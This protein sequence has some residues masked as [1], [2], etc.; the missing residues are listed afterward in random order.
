ML[1]I[2]DEDAVNLLRFFDDRQ[3]WLL[4]ADADPVRLLPYARRLRETETP[5][6]TPPGVVS[7]LPANDGSS[8]E[9]GDRHEHLPRRTGQ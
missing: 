9:Q 7:G 3:A 2:G 5:R 4:L 6:P 1:R 8:S